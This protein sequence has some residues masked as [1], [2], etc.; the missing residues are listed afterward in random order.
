MNL[1]MKNAAIDYAKRGI[2]VIPLHTPVGR[3]SCSCE[4]EG[5]TNVGKHPRVKNWQKDATINL[6]TI[7][8]WWSSW[9]DAN[10]GLL[11]GKKFNVLDIDYKDSGDVSLQC[12][13]EKH[14]PLPKTVISHTGNG[15]H[16]LFSCTDGNISNKV[17]L[18]S[19][20]DIRANNGMIVAPPSLHHS[21][22]R[23]EWDNDNNLENTKIE[24]MPEW[25]KCELTKT[26]TPHS[27]ESIDN[28]DIIPDGKRNDTLF[29][30]GCSLVKNGTSIETIFDILSKEN[31]DRC[32]P[33]LSVQ[34]IAKI[35]QSCERY[36]KKCEEM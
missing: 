13:E 22:K 26:N 18:F 2:P 36:A 9:P 8:K 7:E 21:K 30:I 14:G 12:L 4:S 20:I 10:I 6:T 17:G 32:S 34:E 11:C 29:K 24:N 3:A 25:L 28:D 23:Y 15:K 35:S 31:I 5:C 19:G 33:P 16:I 27:Q 1:N